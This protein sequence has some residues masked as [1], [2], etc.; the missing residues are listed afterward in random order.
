MTINVAAIRTVIQSAR[1]KAKAEYE[2]AKTDMQARHAAE[3]ADLDAQHVAGLAWADQ[4]LA[5]DEPANSATA[6]E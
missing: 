3:A 6:A 4:V 5:I 1:D 2:A